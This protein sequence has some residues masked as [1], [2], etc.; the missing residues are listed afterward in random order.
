MPSVGKIWAQIMLVFNRWNCRSFYSS[1]LLV[2]QGIGRVPEVQNEVAW[3]ARD[4]YSKI[5]IILQ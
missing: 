1:P 3:D 4:R 5:G 2:S